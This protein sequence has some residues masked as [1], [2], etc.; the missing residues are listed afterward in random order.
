MSDTTLTKKCFI[1]GGVKPID[2]FYKHP[3]MSDGH[4]NK[5]KECTKKYMHS[6]QVSGATKESD[7]KRYRENPIRYQKHTWYSIKVRCTTAIKGHEKYLGREFLSL[8]E[9]MEWC[10]Q[11]EEIFTPLYKNWAEHGYARKYAPSIDRIDNSRGYVLGNLQ[12]LTQ[13][14]NS[15]KFTKDAF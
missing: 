1:C 2:D 13:S 9:W 15:R 6:R 12:W 4:L 5:C 14:E 8:D 7:Q 11:T 10:K 3:F